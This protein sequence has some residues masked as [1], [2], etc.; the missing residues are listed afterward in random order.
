M[1]PETVF[2]VLLLK[3]KSITSSSLATATVKVCLKYIGK[4]HSILQKDS[5]TIAL[6]VVVDS[7][8]ITIDVQIVLIQPEVS[9]V[10]DIV[11]VEIAIWVRPSLYHSKIR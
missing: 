10:T 2:L 9:V 3:L 1:K 6:I 4:M 7:S 11:V 5:M 8:I